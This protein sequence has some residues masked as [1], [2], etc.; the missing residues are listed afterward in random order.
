MPGSPVDLDAY[1]ERVGYS[2]D[3]SPTL[4][5]LEGV[6][7]AHAQAIAFENI[8][9]FFGETVEL[10]LGSLQDKLVGSGRGGYCYEQNSLFWHVLRAMGFKVTGLAARVRWNIPENIVI[11]RTHMLLLVD[12]DGG[13]Y[14]TDVGF[15]GLTPTGPLRLAAEIEQATPHESFRL[16]HEEGLYTVEAKWAGTWKALYSFD[17]QEQFDPD[18]EMM[19]WYQSTWPLSPFVQDLVAARAAPG[20]RHALFNDQYVVH[21]LDGGTEKKTLSDME[22]LVY[23]LENVFCLRLPDDPEFKTEFTRLIMAK[24]TGLGA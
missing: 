4:G 7:V 23:T 18:Y 6:H 5:T 9:P 10:D 15:G 19:N 20:C 21:H 24:R 13:K 1:C 14:I 17:L 8:S 12:L 3:R 11:P 22:E 16:M 2:Q